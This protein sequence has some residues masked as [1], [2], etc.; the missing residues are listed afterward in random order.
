M[1]PLDHMT[2][3]RFR[4]ERVRHVFEE[5]FSEVIQLLADMG[6]VTLDTYCRAADS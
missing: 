1:R 5:V 3:N 6:L 2:I 4:T